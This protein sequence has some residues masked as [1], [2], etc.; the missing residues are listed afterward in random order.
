MRYAIWIGQVFNFLIYFTGFGVVTYY[1]SPH[2]GETWVDTLDG[3]SLI[4]MPWWQTMSALIVALDIYIFVLPLPALLKLK[5]PMRRKI[6][7]IAI[8]SLAVM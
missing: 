3:R 1:S 4:G 7:L 5:V 8:F 6:Q 2:I